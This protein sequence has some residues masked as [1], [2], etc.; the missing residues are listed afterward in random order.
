MTTAEGARL[1]QAEVDDIRATAERLLANIQRVIVGNEQVVRLALVALLC[2]GH[3]LLEDVPG[4]AKTVLARA[5]G[6][7]D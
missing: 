1:S 6:G 2:E 7:G 5:I 4:T 3:I